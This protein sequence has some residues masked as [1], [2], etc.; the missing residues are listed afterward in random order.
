MLRENHSLRHKGAHHT[1]VA[2]WECPLFGVKG[3]N[4]FEDA[5]KEDNNLSFQLGYLPA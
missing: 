2:H 4:C 1:P 3:R 5:I